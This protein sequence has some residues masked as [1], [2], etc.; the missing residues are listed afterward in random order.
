MAAM[1]ASKYRISVD[2]PMYSLK[3][4]RKYP[5]DIVEMHA[6]IASI[7]KSVCCLTFM[8]LLRVRRF[9]AL[10]AGESSAGLN[11]QKVNAFCGKC[12]HLAKEK[13]M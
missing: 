8:Q 6:P 12:F 7:R 1:A 9:L 2:I 3:T 5:S 13:R 10:T 4:M 11:L